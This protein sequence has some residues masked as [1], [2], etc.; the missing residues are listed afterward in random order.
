M[1]DAVFISD[2]DGRFVDFNKAFA[3]F[4]RFE[5]KKDCLG[6]LAEYPDILDV[7]MADGTL[8]P[9][10]M[11]AVPRALRGEEVMNAEYRIR[12]K[13]TGESWIGSYNFAP[14]RDR[15][16]QIVGSV[17]VGRDITEQ[18]RAAEALIK[19][20]SLYRTL[21]ENIPQ[22]IFMKDRNFRWVSINQ[23]FANDLGIG[24]EDA[25]G[26]GDHDFF[27]RELAD[28]Y[29]A[30]DERIMQ[31]GETDA[32]EEKYVRGGQEHWVH[33]VKAPVRDEKGDVIGVFG[34]FSD[35]TEHKR[36]QDALRYS[37]ERYRLLFESMT[38]GFVLH[39]IITDEEGRPCD[40]RFLEMNPACERL[41]G[42]RGAEM[43]GRRVREITTESP[44]IER[45]G[46]VALTGKPERFEEYS[47]TLE[48]WLEVFAFQPRPGQCAAVF[49]DTTERKLVENALRESN[50]K[51]NTLIQSSPSAI[52]ALDRDGNITSWNAAA[53]KTYGWEEK[54]VIGR[55][56]PF[57]PE[58]SRHEFDALRERVLSGNGFHDVEIVRVRKDG[59][60]VHISLSVA[61]LRDFS[62]RIN[63]IMSISHDITERTQAAEEKA[64][65]E[66]QYRQ[67]Q[68]ME[69]LGLL[70]GGVAHD[71]NNMLG[72]ILGYAELAMEK[73]GPDHPVVADL[74]QILSAADRSADLTRQ[75]LAFAR[76]QT[77]APM[78]LDLN[79]T[80]GGMVKM[81][82]RLIGEDI[83]L[84][85]LPGENLWSVKVD[86]AQIDQILANLCVNARDAIAGIGKIT[87]ETGHAVFDEFYHAEH[88]EIIPG[89]YVLL[90]VSDDGSGMDKEILDRLFEPFFTTK[91]LGRGTGLGLATVYGIVKQNHGFV[92]VYSEPGQGS[93]FKI[94]LPRRRA[95]AERVQKK[96]PASLVLTGNETIL[97]VEDDVTILKM[98]SL[99]LE[100]QGYTVLAASTPGEAIRLAGEFTGQVHLLMTDVIM[101]EMNGRDLA[102]NL[103]SRFPDL[104]NLFMSGY[105]ANV[106]SHH[107]VLKEGVFFI[108]KPFTWLDLAAKVR[109]VLDSA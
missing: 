94:Y 49:T 104:K 72:V 23:N 70:A 13:D 69:S 78:V 22:K 79:E 59:S 91:G 73:V 58:K 64:R 74:Q 43:I 5:D 51:L 61:P 46:R 81:L 85:W 57:I 63:G 20:E 56:P 75:M 107:G 95:K 3:T 27:P 100:R 101:P 48:M 68:K 29:R 50:E 66:D 1:A 34:I 11:W 65:M 40:L 84:A 109:E 25:V 2:A 35:I 41:T 106:I 93:T 82:S 4:H 47:T 15:D 77:V 31:T 53:T 67:S 76:K 60:D 86:P 97:L 108:Q 21:V 39:E 102:K 10:D 16:G 62:G 28:K 55:Y 83:D 87:I 105:T 17:V 24:P 52:I 26:K 12:R 88:G 6:T 36:A 18:K 98:T 71:F 30:D 92:N 7:F 45:Y 8:A 99:I 42:L 103:M 96:D 37:E 14:I 44:W 9:L 80:V 33:T 89:E 32:F 54:E 38:E 90:A 19:S